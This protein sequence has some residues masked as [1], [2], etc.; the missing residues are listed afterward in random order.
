[1]IDIIL[2]KVLEVGVAK[3]IKEQSNSMFDDIIEKAKQLGKRK[4]MVVF[5]ATEWEDGYDNAK[6]YID[7]NQENIEDWSLIAKNDDIMYLILQLGKIS[8]P[9]NFKHIMYIP[10]EMVEP[11]EVENFVG[12]E[13]ILN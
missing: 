2:N 7:N 9:N 13:Q 4:G 11:E 12:D 8:N 6:E 10:F 3:I 5:K 1:M